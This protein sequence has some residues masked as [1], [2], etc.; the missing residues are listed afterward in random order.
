[1]SHLITG[2]LLHMDCN[3]LNITGKFSIPFIFQFQ[4]LF[5]NLVFLIKIKTDICKPLQKIITMDF[6]NEP[7]FEPLRILFNNAPIE[8]F[9]GMTPNEIH[10][11]L[12]NPFDD[13]SPLKINTPIDNET[14]S[15]IPFFRL[16]EEL[17]KIVQREKQ[18]KLTRHGAL[19]KKVLLELYDHKFIKERF[20]ETG[21]TKL[22]R[23]IDA[24]SIITAHYAARVSGIL[25][26]VKGNLLLTK[27]G[28]MF[29]QTEKRT[30]FF[31]K[32][33]KGYTT[34]FNWASNDDYTDFQVGQFGWGFT[35]FLLYKFGS[36]K[37][38]K[39]FYADKFLK[40][41]PNF[42]QMISLQ[43]D[44]TPEKDFANCYILRS[45]ER[46]AE[47]FGFAEDCTHYFFDRNNN[48]VIRKDALTKVFRFEV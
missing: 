7:K 22:S 11:L 16:T 8:D 2:R 13:V 3:I 20:I 47:W 44:S 14:L 1:M 10:H 4:K 18:I 37:R 36:T 21:L 29:L 9:C 32:V 12:Y 38:T 45:F 6:L 34:E 39:Q 41:F 31:L 28:L 15:N 33:L 43:E 40:A 19:P 35:M 5:N 25:K 46:F 23:E 26:K 27:S 24:P 42:I 17:L 30:D 48:I